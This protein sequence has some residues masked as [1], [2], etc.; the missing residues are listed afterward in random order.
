MFSFSW[1]AALK[2]F[3]T[4]SANRIQAALSKNQALRNQVDFLSSTILSSHSLPDISTW[5]KRINNQQVL[6]EIFDG[7][8]ERVETVGEHVEL[9]EESKQYCEMAEKELA[10]KDF[11]VS[12]AKMNLLRKCPIS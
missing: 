2:I 3:N 11:Q 1:E 9:D 7:L 12:S 5:S 8:K 4:P 6:Q 10:D